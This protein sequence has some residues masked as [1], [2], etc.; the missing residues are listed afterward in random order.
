MIDSLRGF[1]VRK[2]SPARLLGTPTGART[3]RQALVVLATLLLAYFLGKQPSLT[4]V[5]LPIGLA[6][7]WLIY[8]HPELAIVGMV[9]A[10]LVVPFEIGTGTQSPLNAAFV[11]VPILG[12]LWLVEMVRNRSIRLAPSSTNLPLMGLI[13]TASLSLLVG[14]L[15]WNV[16]AQLAPIRAQ[17]GAWGIFVFSAGA[18]WL[19]ANRIRDIRWLK[20]LVWVFL[21]LAAL[22]ILGRVTGGLGGAILRLFPFGSTGSLFWIWLV[23]L[24]A[25][26]VLFNRDLAWRWRL[27]LVALICITFVVALTGDARGWAS[28]WVPPLVGLAVLVGFRWPRIVLLAGFVGVLVVLLNVPT[29]QQ[30]ILDYKSYDLLTRG[31]ALSIVLEIFKANPLLG[32]GPANYYYYTPLY[33]ILGYYVR[34]NSHNNYID[35]LA[36]TGLLGMFFFTWFAAATARLGWTLRN[37]VTGGFARAYVFS[38]LAGL[39]ASLAA[40][41]LGDWLLPFVYNIGINGFR[42]SILGWLFLGGLV[43]LEQITNK[44]AEAAALA[45]PS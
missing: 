35:I 4:Y 34:F 17:L 27:A 36:Q 23:V 15:P 3:A 26:Q 41:A 42:A 8:T 44:P 38:C 43:A 45:T 5:W 21:A 11:A 10:A 20:R 30:L 22:Y 6:I 18:F 7:T 13:L 33:P 40:G 39:I 14:Y 37:K 19:G 9:V 16:F 1:S 12:G 31:A 32:V 29:A 28:G 24:A 2:L 25:G